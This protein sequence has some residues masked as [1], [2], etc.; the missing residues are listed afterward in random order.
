MR[1]DGSGEKRPALVR[2]I[3]TDPS[4]VPHAFLLQLENGEPADPAVFVDAD[5]R[6]W[7]LGDS[8]VARDG[9]RW[10]IASVDA[11]PAQLAAEGVRGDLDRHAGSPKSTTA[12]DRSSAC[13][14]VTRRAVA[15]PSARRIP[16]RIRAEDQR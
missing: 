2:A 16:R 9:S 7:M 10:R 15:A 13:V 3:L 6:S 1:R 12:S 11:V 14:P 4:T 5:L 8:F